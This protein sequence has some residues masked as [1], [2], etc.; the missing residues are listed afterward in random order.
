MT[1]VQRTGCSLLEYIFSIHFVSI[2]RSGID[3]PVF[4]TFYFYY[5]DKR[6][7]KYKCLCSLALPFKKL[8]D[9]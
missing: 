5:E 6:Q 2:N 1:S 3:F 9:S 4:V 7:K 8:F